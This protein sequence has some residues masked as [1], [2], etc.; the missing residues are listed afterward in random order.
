MAPDIYRP[1]KSWI[2]LTILKALALCLLLGIIFYDKWYACLLL[3]PCGIMM[4]HEEKRKYLY[5]IKKRIKE[6]F[7]DFVYYVSSCLEAGY[8][9]EGAFVQGIRQYEES[10]GE[11]VILDRLKIIANGMTYTCSLEQ[12]LID[13][14]K[15]CGI[16][17]I[18][19][20]GEAIALSK[21]YGGN[22]IRVIKSAEGE[23][24]DKCLV[25][26]EIA[27]LIAAKRLEGKIMLLSPI[28]IILYMR[29]INKAYMEI[30]YYSLP[31][32]LVMT[33]GVFVIAVSALWINKIV[34]I[35]V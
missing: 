35:E 22:I 2:V 33:F 28:M 17:E 25:E 15:D 10:P 3:T 16:K 29:F 19:D 12:Q 11:S 21:R 24:R 7:I 26:K 14:G 20:L 6:D 23:Y 5:T 9:L 27:T 13:F 1:D 31:G 32:R 30:L 4:W 8:S 18:R 34:R